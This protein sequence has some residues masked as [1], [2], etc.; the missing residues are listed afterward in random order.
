[1]PQVDETNVNDLVAIALGQLHLRVLVLTAE[2]ALVEAGAE[3]LKQAIA[4]HSCAGTPIVV[5]D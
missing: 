1:M 3:K 2:K 4:T 5:K